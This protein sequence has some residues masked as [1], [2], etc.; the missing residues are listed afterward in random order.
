[1]ATLTKIEVAE[2]IFYVTIPE[3]DLHILCGC[4]A[5]SVKHLMKRGLIQTKEVNGVAFETGPNAIL[6]SDVLIQNGRFTNLSEFPILQMF[7]RQG[8]IIPGHPNN[9]GVKPVL[10]GSRRQ[11]EAQMEYIYRGNYGLVNKEEIMQA[12]VRSETAKQMMRLKLKFAFGRIRRMD[13]YLDLVALENE[14]QEIRNQVFIKRLTPN[15]FE[16][17]HE[18]QSVRVDLNLPLH[19]QVLP[20]Y[21][22]GFHQIKRDYF[23]V[24]HSGEGDGWDINRPAMASILLFQGKVY[25]IDAGPNIMHSLNALGISVNEIAGVFHTHA[26]DDHFCGLPDL[27]RADHRIPYYATA[28]VRTSVMKKL[29]ALSMMNEDEF[30]HYFDFRDLVMDQWNDID[31]LEVKPVFSPHPVETTVMFF[32]TLD[33]AGYRSYAHFADIAS[34]K[35][36]RGMITTDKSAPGISQELYDSVA[37]SYLTPVDLKKLDIGGGMIHGDAEDFAEDKS[38]K[39]ILA[40]TALPLTNRQKEIG[41]GAPFGTVDVLIASHQDYVRSYALDSLSRYFPNVPDARLRVLLNNPVVTFNPESIIFKAGR[42]A[43]CVYLLLT[44]QVDMIHTKKQVYSTLSS[45]AMLGEVTALTD[46]PCAETYRAAN[47]VQALRIPI[48]LY[49]GFVK[50]S[51]LFDRMVRQ[52]DVQSFLYTNRLFGDAMSCTRQNAI[53]AAIRSSFH[54]KGGIIEASEAPRLRLI[55][56]GTVELIIGDRVIERLKAGDFFCESTV[57]FGIPC[58]FKAQAISDTELY[59][60]P[61]VVLADVPIIRWKLLEIYETRLDLAVSL[62]AVSD[63]LV[64]QEEYSIGIDAIDREHRKLFHDAKTLYRRLFADTPSNDMGPLFQTLLTT[65]QVHFETEESLMHE[66]RYPGLRAHAKNHNMILSTLSD[67]SHD[68]EALKSI[69][70]MDVGTFIKNHVMTHILTED[71]KLGVY[72]KELDVD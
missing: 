63:P 35:L 61:A 2:G 7:Y 10:I 42:R 32:R 38:G 45:G 15:V 52:L 72:L 36:L 69:S 62:D 17:S 44:G 49:C 33:R 71:R 70:K 68:Y 14:Q 13:E 22:L 54:S 27:M 28:M 58:L 21:S 56:S 47:F 55:K 4:P 46:R 26:H 29:A 39:I 60:I 51:G 65:T 48:D 66:H 5:D 19:S 41:S 20:S 40:H 67:I 59:E 24:L 6:L 43:D 50:D 57:L 30:K 25:L 31:T 53:A 23:S 12:G 8:R 1:M 64:W 11:V 9:A 3:A 16:I 18:K 34:L 37:Q